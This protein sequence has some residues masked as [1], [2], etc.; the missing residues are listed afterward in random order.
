M[1]FVV[2]SFLSGNRMK[3]RSA[4]GR[5]HAIRRAPLI[6]AGFRESV[7]IDDE[8]HHTEVSSS[9]PPR[10]PGGLEWNAGENG[11]MRSREAGKWGR[12]KVFCAC[13]EKALEKRTWRNH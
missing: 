4:A 6:R 10:P 8:T 2:N 5:T 1:V 3:K 9:I 7:K 11:G 13:E 12:K